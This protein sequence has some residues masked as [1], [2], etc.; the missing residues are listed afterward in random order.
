VRENLITVPRT[1]EN[2]TAKERRF[3]ER[4]PADLR[5]DYLALLP[6][7]TIDRQTARNRARNLRLIDERIRLLEKVTA[8]CEQRLRDL[9]RLWGAVNDSQPVDM[10]EV[11]R[12]PDVPGVTIRFQRPAPKKEAPAPP[13]KPLLPI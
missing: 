6:P 5:E 3:Y 12:P 9:R 1:V 13:E 8:A 2:L 11:N 10:R 4:L 7:L